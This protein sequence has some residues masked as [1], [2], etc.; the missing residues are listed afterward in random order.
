MTI[1][2][3][4]AVLSLPG[5][6]L[7]GGACDGGNAG[8]SV[9]D[10]GGDG[11]FTISISADNP[12]QYDW[13]DPAGLRLVVERLDDGQVFWRIVATDPDVG[14]TPPV[15]HGISP[16]GAD[17]EVDQGALVANEEFR[18]R[19]TRIDGSSSTRTFSP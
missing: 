10:T 6:A 11:D 13:P 12:P 19:L 8:L 14:F 7:V 17:E 4:T 18:V 3:L 1:R 15:T 9:I 5:L 16:V 2:T